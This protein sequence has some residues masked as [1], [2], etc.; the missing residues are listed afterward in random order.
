M[1]PFLEA[2]SQNHSA[3]NAGTIDL[4]SPNNDP[5][6][7]SSRFAFSLWRS[8]SSPVNQ[9]VFESSPFYQHHTPVPP[10]SFSTVLER[11]DHHR[12][13]GFS[14]GIPPRAH[15]H[16]PAVPPH[17]A[18]PIPEESFQL[19]SQR[20][21]TRNNRIMRN[22]RTR[23]Q[24]NSMKQ[25]HSA[26]NPA[27][28]LR[29]SAK[30]QTLEKSR[31]NS[32]KRK[33]EESSSG[34]TDQCCICLENPSPKDKATINGCDHNFCFACIETWSERENT[35]PLCKARFTQIKRN[36]DKKKPPK[37]SIKK[38]KHRDQRSDTDPSNSF[39]GWLGKFYQR[40]RAQIFL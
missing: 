1:H 13:P 8:Q 10:T 30:T 27:P 6:S 23:N 40:N 12:S 34:S 21:A 24:T 25:Q 19:P 22:S 38:V 16:P 2:T 37:S 39:Q 32:K 7:P 31:A 36:S 29:A 17:I 28:F 15:H 3:G 4:M 5:T 35:C 9:N 14:M 20:V 26:A 18:A 33:L 11:F